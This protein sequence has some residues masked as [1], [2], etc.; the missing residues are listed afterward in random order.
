MR[1]VGATVPEP[2]TL[3]GAGSDRTTANIAAPQS[4]QNRLP[5]W[6]VAPHFAHRMARSQ[7]SIHPRPADDCIIQVRLTVTLPPGM[8]LSSNTKFSK[9]TCLGN[10]TI[11]PTY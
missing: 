8:A 7:Y 1:S 6:L 10:P 4:A 2:A 3:R 11:D 9:S 5:S